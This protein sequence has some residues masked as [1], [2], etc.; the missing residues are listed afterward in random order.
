[1]PN[2]F[3]ILYVEPLGGDSNG[4][5]TCRVGMLAIASGPAQNGVPVDE[6]ARCFTQWLFVL[7]ALQAMKSVPQN[8]A[9]ISVSLDLFGAAWGLYLAMLT[10]VF[11]DLLSGF[12][13]MSSP[14]TSP[15]GN[16]KQ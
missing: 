4:N 9:T 16:R 15:A 2:L 10:V 6:H 1:M 7:G 8:S 5:S 12:P 14:I 11:L 3:A 13:C